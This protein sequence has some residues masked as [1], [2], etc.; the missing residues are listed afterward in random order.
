MA[1]DAI[2]FYTLV[3]QIYGHGTGDMASPK[4]LPP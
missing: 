4:V 2:Y 1:F 3:Y